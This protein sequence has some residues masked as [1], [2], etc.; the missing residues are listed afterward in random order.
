MNANPTKE[1]VLQVWVSSEDRD[2]AG[3]DHDFYMP[4]STK[5]CDVNISNSQDKLCHVETCGCRRSIFVK[6]EKGVVHPTV[7]VHFVE[8]VPFYPQTLT[9]RIKTPGSTSQI[10]QA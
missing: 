1:R 8:A 4:H 2:M 9:L 5:T 3:D 7:L 6:P 10:E